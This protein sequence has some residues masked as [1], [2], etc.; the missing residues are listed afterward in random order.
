MPPDEVWPSPQRRAPGSLPK[1]GEVTARDAPLPNRPTLWLF[2]LVPFFATFQVSQIMAVAISSI[3]CFEQQV[4]P[5]GDDLHGITQS[6]I[7]RAAL[8]ENKDSLG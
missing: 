8:L 6:S 4:P 3:Q 7:C 2:Y 5:D 1:E